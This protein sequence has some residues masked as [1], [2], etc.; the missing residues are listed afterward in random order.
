MASKKSKKGIFRRI[1]QPEPDLATD[2]RTAILVQSPKGGRYILW[3]I[4]VLFLIAVVWAANSQ[5]DQVTR[6]QGKVIPSRHVQVVQNLEGGILEE[7]L[8]NVGD[9]VEKGQLLLKIDDTRFSAPYKESRYKYLALRA[10][11]ARLEAETMGKEFEPPEEVVTENPEI[12]EREKDLFRSRKQ[13]IEAEVAVLEEQVNQRIQELAELHAREGQLKRSF[14]LL[15]SEMEMTRPLVSQGAVSRVE[16]LR[17]E[18]EANKVEGDLESTRLQIPIVQSKLQEVRRM[19]EEKKLNYYNEAKIELNHTLSELEAISV[20]AVA[21][22]DRLKRTHVRS[23]VHGTIKQILVN[24]VGGVIKPGMDLIEIVPLEDTLL[25]ETKIKPSDI[26]FLHPG[27]EARVM[28]SAYDFTIY[29]GLE[30][31][32][33]H[34]SADSITD[35]KG[36]S[37]YLVR[38]RTEKNHLGSDDDPMPIIPGMLATVEILTGKNTI[39]SYLLK[40]ALRARKLALKER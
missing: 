39:L 5:I 2:I 1:P 34:I 29:G 14:E 11:A 13:A 10:K 22:E 38:V 4:I 37:Y 17:L 33:E 31:K 26:A 32:V 19:I 36:D 24:T 18:R 27:Q 21:L 30:G 12:A 35:E 40:P 6:G 23:P 8:V 25:I 7:I 3:L 20:A 16:M 28:F 9:T 15:R